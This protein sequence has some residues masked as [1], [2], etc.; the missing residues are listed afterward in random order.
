MVDEHVMK[1]A[2]A[3]GA[4]GHET[5]NHFLDIRKNEGVEA[6]KAARAAAAKRAAA[7]QEPPD[8]A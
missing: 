2:D 8:A 5:E 3:I 7:A 4:P 1:G 6:E